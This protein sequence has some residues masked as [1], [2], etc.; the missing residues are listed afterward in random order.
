M[1]L[2][3][4]YSSLSLTHKKAV[5]PFSLVWDTQTP[6]NRTVDE[7]PIPPPLL[8]TI[9]GKPSYK[10]DAPPPFFAWEG[11]GQPDLPSSSSV[12]TTEAAAVLMPP[13]TPSQIYGRPSFID[14]SPP[15]YYAWNGAA[16]EGE[17]ADKQTPTSTQDK[18]YG[19]P[20]FKAE[21][22]PV[23]Y[24]W[25][26]ASAAHAD[27]K[28]LLQGLVDPSFVAGRP[29]VVVE[30]PPYYY[31]W[32]EKQPSH[33]SNIHASPLLL[34]DARKIQHNDDNNHTTEVIPYFNAPPPAIPQPPVRGSIGTSSAPIG[35]RTTI[36]RVQG[37]CPSTP[38]SSDRLILKKSASHVD[39]SKMTMMVT[40][41][42][43]AVSK[44]ANA[45]VSQVVVPPKAIKT[46]KTGIVLEMSN[47]ATVPRRTV[48]KVVGNGMMSNA[49]NM[50]QKQSRPVATPPVSVVR[51][52][53]AAGRME[54]GAPRDPTLVCR[55]LYP[56]T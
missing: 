37:S 15:V 14:V 6:S 49:S 25:S 2:L 32:P 27:E 40:R 12:T 42:S 33:P 28:T 35:N 8:D 3:T 23:Y 4:T 43:T 47:V 9:A 24:A 20:S 26:G 56:H 19:R 53:S 46:T 29:S 45:V 54:G 30:R 13:P 7:L 48:V 41:P 39:N 5:P 31:A 22:P 44:A 16:G 55:Q 17:K 34:K 1:V 10:A 18:I 36:D 50:P 38:I 21:S 52:R 51:P 11:P